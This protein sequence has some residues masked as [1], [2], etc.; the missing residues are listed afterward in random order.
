MSVLPLLTNT[1]AG[2]LIGGMIFFAVVV[3]PA[4]FTA[5]EAQPAGR[6]LRAVFPRYYLYLIV[7][8]TGL[9]LSVLPESL[10]AAGSFA[11]VAASTC[12]VRQVLVARINRARDQMEE[13]DR[14]A[15]A[16]FA[17]GHRLSVMINLLQLAVLIGWWVA[18]YGPQP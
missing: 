2:L 6:F 1:L 13:G 17:R 9:A 18:L 15:A 5:L 11:V 7:L 3:A 4:V 12:W 10:W 14:H 16:R 8:S